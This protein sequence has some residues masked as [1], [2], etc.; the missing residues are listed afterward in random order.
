MMEHPGWI[1]HSPA[2]VLAGLIKT[3]RPK[4]WVKNI[5]VGVALV[6]SQRLSDPDSVLRALMAFG[7]FCLISGCVYVVNDLVDVEKDRAHPKKR[8]RPIAS[9]ALPPGAATVFVVV[10]A[11]ATVVGA[12]ALTPWL[13]AVVGG[14]FVQNLLYCFWIKRVP[15]LDVFSIATGFV[16][17]V[18]AG[19]LAIDVPAS[20]WLMVNMALLALFLGFGKRAHELATQDVSK[21]RPSLAGY[22][23]RVLKG[24]LYGLAVAALGAYG[25]YTQSSHVKEVFGDAQ[26]IYTL[27]FA[28]LGIFRFM[29]LI[30]TRTDAESPTDEML[31]DPAFV[32]NFFLFLAV[33]GF[34]LYAG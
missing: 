28:A 27:P 31:R 3:L 11:P 17:R 34:V 14:Y 22:N 32:I 12:Y 24:I 30:T 25:A 29:R 33:T 4:Q 7:L 19:A 2:P 1:C 26:L 20:E 21:T 13:A 8:S 5:F 6:F 15:Y 16:L 9:G 10:A 23:P 18:L